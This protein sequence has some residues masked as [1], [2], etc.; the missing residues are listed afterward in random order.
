MLFLKGTV[1]ELQFKYMIAEV[2]L[3]DLAAAEI[4]EPH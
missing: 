2:P 1:Q 4:K 3:E